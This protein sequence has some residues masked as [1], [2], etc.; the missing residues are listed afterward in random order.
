MKTDEL[1]EQILKDM[2][3]IHIDNDGNKNDNLTLQSLSRGYAVYI[4]GR[5][6]GYLS[7]E[8]DKLYY[9]KLEEIVNAETNVLDSKEEIK[10]SEVAL[11]EEIYNTEVISAMSEEFL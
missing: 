11:L 8:F 10:Q 4:N 3:K 6:S 5:F 7:I 2:I 9:D 1:K